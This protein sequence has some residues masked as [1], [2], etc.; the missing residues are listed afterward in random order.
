MQVVAG[1][2][3]A[4]MVRSLLLGKGSNSFSLVCSKARNFHGLMEVCSEYVA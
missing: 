1:T 4:G 3:L 2:E